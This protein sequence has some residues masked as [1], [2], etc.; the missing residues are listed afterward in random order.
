MLTPSIT[1][2]PLLARTLFRVAQPAAASLPIA[3][4]DDLVA[5]QLSDNDLENVVGG[6]ARVRLDGLFPEQSI[7]T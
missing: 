1:V 3:P 5:D 6:L 2:T 4:I 7:S